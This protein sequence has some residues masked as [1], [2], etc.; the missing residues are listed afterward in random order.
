MLASP[1]HVLSF[2][3]SDTV[4]KQWFARS[5]AFDAATR[6]ALGELHTRAAAGAL[7]N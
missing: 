3:Y 7:D 1:D 5:D 2:W 4:C 6:E